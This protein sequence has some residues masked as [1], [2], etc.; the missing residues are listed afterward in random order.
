MAD[1]FHCGLDSKRQERSVARGILPA[2]RLA[3]V[4]A[5]CM[6]VVPPKLAPLLRRQLRLGGRLRSKNEPGPVAGASSTQSIVASSLVRSKR[7]GRLVKS[8]LLGV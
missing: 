6:Q 5:T 7:R 2:L 8:R 3:T 4:G 1:A